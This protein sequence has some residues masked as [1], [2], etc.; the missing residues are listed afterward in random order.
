MALPVALA[1]MGG[2]YLVENSRKKLP[3]PSENGMYHTEMHVKHP[4]M[5][6]S[7]SLPPAWETVGEDNRMA[8]TPDP[9]HP[10]TMIDVHRHLLNIHESQ[11]ASSHAL[12]ELAHSRAP[13]FLHHVR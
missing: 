1:M 5:P 7:M 4:N 2:L 10:D 12:Q 3:I 9:E 6:H 13:E 11:A 8:H